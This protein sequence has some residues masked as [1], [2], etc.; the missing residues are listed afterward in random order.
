VLGLFR[1]LLFVL[2]SVVTAPAQTSATDGKTPT[3]LAPGSPAGSYALSG[4][5][6]VNL[7]NGGLNFRL[8]LLKV[9]GRG[10]AGYAVT[11]PVE[12]KWIVKAGQPS[13]PGVVPLTPNPNWWQ[14]I[15]PG[16]GPGV[17][18]GRRGNYEDGRAYDSIGCDG[19]GQG[20]TTVLREVDLRTLT[21]LTFTASDGTEYE[22]RDQSTDGAPHAD[23]W[24]PQ[25]G[26]HAGFSRGNVFVTADGTSATFISDGDITD[27]VAPNMTQSQRLIYPSGF[28]L[29]PDGMRYRIDSGTVSWVRDRNGN[30]VTFAYG[31]G[32]RI[33]SVTDELGRQVTFTYDDGLRHYEE[34]TFSG[35]GGA[36]RTVRVWYDSL[37][38]RLRQNSGYSAQTYY[39]LFPLNSAS[40]TT[41]YN[42]ASKVSEVE[43]PNGRRYELYYNPYGE[44]ARV[45]LPTGGAVEYDWAGGA[46][47]VDAYIF[48]YVTKRRVYPNGGTTWE[49][50]T[51]YVR[52]GGGTNS[53][54]EEK[55]TD[56]AGALLARALHYF[57][58]DAAESMIEDPARPG[59]ISYS[60]W[61][62]GREYRTESYDVV[63]GT[64]VLKRVVEQT[65]QQP[66]A[67]APWPLSGQGETDESAKPNSSQVT[68]VNTTLS[69]TN[70]VSKQTFAYDL[71]GNRTDAWEYD[72]G[73][74]SAP[75]YAARH[76]H[77]DYETAVNY[78]N[79]D[80]DPALGASLRALPRAQ[81]VYSV[82]PSTGA[83][84]IAAK[85]EMRYDEAAYPLLTYSGITV[86]GWTDPVSAARG[87]A[88]SVRSFVD[89]T[90]SADP[91]QACPTGVCVETHARYDQLGNLRYSWD[92]RGNKSEALYGDS[93]CNGTTC[94]TTGYTPNTFAFAI[95]TKT[96]KPDLA[97]AY[98]SA[99]ELTSSAVYD[100]YTGLAYSATDSNGQT[101]HVEYEDQ[102]GQLDRPKA[103]V[104]P[105]GGR[106]DFYYG[107]T[108]GSLY[109][110]TL[111]DLDAGRRTES[112]QY[113]DGLGRVYRKAAYENS[114]AAQPWLNVDT[115][116]D[117][118]GRVAMASMPYRSAGG[119]TPLPAAEWSNAKRSETTYDA[120]GR[121]LR[122]TT[123]P[124]GAF[125]QTDYSGDRVLVKDQAGKERVS[126][127]DAL[128]RLVEVW[129]VTPS[130]SGAEAS[131]VSL[132]AFPGHSEAAY[133]YLTSYRYDAL[134]SLRMVEQLGHHEGQ[135]VTQH[136]FFAYDSLGRLV[137][138]KNP[139]QGNFTSD[140]AGGDFPAL[141]DSTSGVS[142]SQW[143]AGYL[144]DANGNLV[145]RRDAR[146]TTATYSY[147]A[148]NRN[149]KISY[150]I[151]GGAVATP[152]VIHYY[153]N[154]AAEAN[155]LGRPWKSEALQT[156]R[157]TVDL[158]DEV[159]RP[160]K[161]TQQFW[162]N[163]VWGQ[164]YSAQQ[165]YNKA[166]GVTSET[167]PSG[168][169]VYYNYDA[170]GRL[171]DN[172]SSAAFY[173]NLGDG[174][175]RT[176]SSQVRYQ[177]MG[178]REQERFGTDTPV[179]NKG[180][181]NSRGQLA[182][183]RVS[184]YSITSPGQETK[185]N[186]G[187]IINH[188]SDSG[189]GASAAGPDNNGNLHRQDIFIPNFDGP[190]YDQ[191]SNFGVSTESFSYDPLN[192]LQSASE[193]GAAPWTQTYSY[194]R[195][196]NRTIDS[197]T[198]NAPE[199]QFT[200][201]AATNRLGVPV[202]Q[203]GSMS[204]DA[205]GNLTND[206]YQGGQGG[207]GTRAYDA[208]NR[209]TSAQFVNGQLQAAAYTYDGDGRRVKRKV[210]A[211]GEVWQV[212][213]VGGE[214][215]AEYA[216]NASPSSPQ[217]E[218]GYRSGELLVIADAPAQSSGVYDAA[219]QFSGSQ[220]P[221][222]AWSYGYRASGG[223]F[224]P[225]TGSANIFGAGTS[226]WSQSSISWCCPSVTHDD[227]GATLTYQ[228]SPNIV[229]PADTL[230]LHP[231]PNGERSVVKWTAPSSGTYNVVGR[232]QGIDVGTGTTTDV[233][234]THNGAGVFSSAVNGGGAS[235]PFSLT[236][237]VSAGDTLEFSVGVGSNGTYNSDSTGLVVTITPAAQ[238]Y[239]AV[240]DFSAAQN[241]SGAWSYGYKPS[242]GSF[243]TFAS[244][245]NVFGAGAD[246]WSQP[247]VSWC[248]PF[249]TRN[250]TGSTLTYQNSQNIV[251]PSDVLNLHP[252]PSGERSVVRWTA[253]AAS[254]YTVSG[255]FQGLDTNGTTTDVAV[256]KNGVNV[257]TGSVNGYGSQSPFSL[258]VTVAAG[259]TVEF[260]VGVGSN[261]T[262]NS[263]STG[264]AATVTAAGAGSAIQWLVSD[265]LGTPRM[266]VD[267][268]GA[269][270]GVTRHDYY[271]FGEDVPADP[272]WRIT[273]R[274]YSAS[275]DLRQ[276]FAGKE[277]DGETGLDYLLARY[278]CSSQGRFTGVDAAGPDITDPQT[279]NK[280][281]YALNNPLR[282]VDPNGKQEQGESL[283]DSVRNYFAA[284]VRRLKAQLSPEEAQQQE[285]QRPAVGPAINDEFIERYNQVL[286]E[287]VEFA[288]DVIM[289]ADVT[290]AGTAVRGY[291]RGNKTELAIG[292]ASIVAMPLGEIFDVGKS[293][294]T[295][296]RLL[297]GR[298]G[299]AEVAAQFSK[300]GD[301]LVAG[302][303]GVWNK[304][305]TKALGGLSSTT[306]MLLDSVVDYAKKE[307]L[308]KIEVQA[309]AVVNPKL[310][311]LLI[312]QGF[313]KTTVVVEGETVAAYTKTFIVK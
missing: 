244:N 296:G 200:V 201:D 120:L 162:M 214:L 111:S 207:G 142:N 2:L 254:S 68:Q 164:S 20:C 204:Y 292:M 91:T 239:S 267:K 143:S 288:T 304:E 62:E 278:Y 180:L 4:F 300:H 29:F 126:R 60:K 118:L 257:F 34:I 133:G 99:S 7:F 135:M 93:F 161:Q 279:L 280:Y 172:G 57:Y 73:A 192:R 240:S 129:E 150:T 69:D 188:Y 127:A 229:Q 174:A 311:K 122:L 289:L 235:A 210:G 256:S 52:T 191:G 233:S 1:A 16:Y 146:G 226:S 144:Y 31:A 264:L 154:P 47:S 64:P 262:Y 33:A 103:V 32:S 222:G 63:A 54:V 88:T 305:G 219:S 290:G 156:A 272:N 211:G 147:D 107:D 153:D 268:T 76:T 51:E 136:R 181:Y 167:Y 310:E 27:Y 185:W 112:R 228:N 108:V 208:E 21:R 44:L 26:D 225:Y 101:T 248:C 179:Y 259:D 87:N 273:A 53:S 130:E 83:E 277:R 94:G 295:S 160:K 223:A 109:V 3:G 36:A 293:A 284:L 84:T 158:Y 258:T 157:T 59:A 243:T 151:A 102:P 117:A 65:W 291:F 90:A 308:S 199:P 282:Y 15:R 203:G 28:L 251:Q 202:G 30:K 72:Y 230:N 25:T 236:R 105:D 194:D 13:P 98:G 283:T 77:T 80:L 221:S 75:Q 218:Y 66:S 253:Q 82:D 168:H 234:I 104:R 306:R 237:M 140:A 190:G 252:G 123:R 303:L 114:V 137:R 245:A 148:L 227:T 124:D 89:A 100:F 196:G 14:G 43:L 217:K 224:T 294:V 9:G 299:E 40:T 97:G 298:I 81:R 215:L 175:Q 270:S 260:S 285:S 182:E 134:G 249:V 149:I 159:G 189:W 113:F 132:G 197:S 50:Q 96:P 61:R 67:G 163:G 71:Y 119:G 281:R 56:A 46:N 232:F 261:G 41:Q 110:R 171:G 250:S 186:R 116:Y 242:G 187:A 247:S 209:M 145:K 195:W 86:P 220:N 6:T 183:I 231:G 38:N 286:G 170:A 313:T 125:V 58:G 241:P 10:G 238:V 255:R 35:F 55:T 115:A 85:S 173:G 309:I 275:D 74:G 265:Q 45:E 152:E 193:S 138:A 12:Q 269:L 121:V 79:A 128:G 141:T 11:L 274:G 301:T 39:Q 205:A 287:R 307:G 216:A 48:R 78:V 22:L 37:A 271:P 176:Y 8:P 213:G 5:D 155:G 266:V 302:I 106:T 17:L 165:S 198:T 92:A 49:S 131:T 312:K 95:S 263:D 23:T 297:G 276:K 212:Y 24:Y 139:E 42:P 178:G 70:Q 19:V 206:T 166:G 246:S 18:H 169:V 184:T 177:E